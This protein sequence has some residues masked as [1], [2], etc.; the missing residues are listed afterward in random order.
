MHFCELMGT[1]GA[2]CSCATGYRLADD[3]L[4]CEAE[5]TDNVCDYTSVGNH[6]CDRFMT[7]GLPS[8]HALS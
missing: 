6:E 2:R 5:G 4:S 8:S 3:G 7:A 1:F